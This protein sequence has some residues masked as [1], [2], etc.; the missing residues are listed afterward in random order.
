[1]FRNGLAGL[2]AGA[3][4]VLMMASAAMAADPAVPLAA[5]ET[6]TTG[7]GFFVHAGP[8][9]I[10]L[11]EGAKI[12]AG[13]ARVPG[14]TIKVK[15]HFTAAVEAGYF[16]TP[17][18]A[19]SFTG[20]YPPNVKIEAA[21]T[22][23]GMGRVGASTYG[24]M[25]VTMHYH[26]TGLGRLQPYIGAGPAFMYVFDQTDGLMNSLH[27]DNTAGFAFQAGADY[28]LSDRWGVFIDVKK[29]ILR[30]DA[31]GFLGPAPIR[32]DLRL[33]PLVVHTGVTLRF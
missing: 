33:D 23:N 30:T 18:F 27:V 15:R 13:D 19:V 8:A 2:T 16:I 22:M 26:F 1:M 14:G 28:M 24:P 17:N 31:T 4:G 21:G 11:D 12:Y 5:P 7:L 20:G 6:Q 25:T 10:E 3:A 29:A 9:G 32:A